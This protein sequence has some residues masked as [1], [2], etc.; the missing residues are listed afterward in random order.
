MSTTKKDAAE[1][2]QKSALVELIEF[3]A[4]GCAELF[5]Q[6]QG[7]SEKARATTK[8]GR[9]L[10]EVA[11]IDFEEKEMAGIKLM[12]QNLK[13]IKSLVP[14]KSGKV[15]CEVEVFNITTKDSNRVDTYYR[16]IK[17]R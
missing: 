17:V 8:D 3:E 14:V 9:P 12:Q 16:I 10:F 15:L 5:T 13:R 1:A 11:Y 7:S 6:A 4:A 2:S